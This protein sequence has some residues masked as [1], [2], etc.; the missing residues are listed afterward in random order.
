MLNHSKNPYEA[1]IDLAELVDF[2]N[3]N[4]YYAKWIFEQQPYQYLGETNRLDWRPLEGFILAIP[5]F[6]FYSI[7]GN[8]PTAPA[9]VGNVA[10]WKPARSVIFS[11]FE[12]MK[13]LMEAGLPAGVINFV[14]FNS[15]NAKTVLQHP[16]FAGLHFTGSYETLVAIWKTMG[17]KLENYKNFP[18]IVGETGG[19]NFIFM[20]ESADVRGCTI[21]IVRGGF[22]YQGQKCSAASGAYIP[23]SKW[24][25]VRKTLL[26]ELP[27][28]KYGETEDLDNYLGAIIDEPAY[29]KV[30]SYIE[31]AK[32]KPEEYELVY[33]GNHS[34]S[35]GWFVEPT[36]FLSKN[37]KGRLM[38]EEIFGPV[39]TIY[40]YPDSRLEETLQ[41]C[42]NTS[43]FALTGAVFA[44][45]RYAI[46]RAEKVLRFAAGNFYVNDKPTGA[47][48]GRQ[49]FGGA[50]NSGTN[51]KAGSWLNIVRW[52]SPRN[53]KETSTLPRDWKRSFLGS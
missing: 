6:N 29:Q 36:V 32:S 42:S 50:R 44:N 23:M 51:D 25:E 24:D 13:I 52:L 16:S 18:R 10:L 5:P 17:E 35:R 15:K 26:E 20:H 31:Y 2:W 38:T 45:D 37:P 21:N 12:I 8:L 3:F 43:P 9:M 11:N 49:P 40:V 41:L 34:S 30:V 1:E 4:A 19:K 39:M 14:P 48:V 53:I 28:V 27:R 7:A 46:Q 47:I 22:E 33:G